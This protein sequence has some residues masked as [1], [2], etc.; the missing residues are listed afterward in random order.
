MLANPFL[1]PEFLKCPFPMFKQLRDASPVMHMEEMGMYIVTGY[2]E[3][4]EILMNP[5]PFSS[6]MP[7]MGRGSEAAR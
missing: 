2:D 3:A 6:M 1:D 5:D 4:R 7:W